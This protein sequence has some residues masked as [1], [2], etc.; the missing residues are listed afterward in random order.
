DFEFATKFS[1]PIVRVVAAEGEDA[2]TPLAE[3]YSGDGRLVNSGQFDGLGVEEGVARITEWLHEKSS[4]DERVNY[5]LHDWCISR[6]RYGGPPIP[7]VY[8]DACGTV[9]VP[10]DQLPVLLPD[11]EDFR[12]DDTGVSPLARHEAWYFTD[13]PTCGGKAR[14]ET[15]VSD[16][17]L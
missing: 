10:E 13:C 16:T 6:Q 8:C 4:A 7:I 5:R 17:F 15:D 2:R 11:V 12:P 9:P 14:R 3:A 1:L